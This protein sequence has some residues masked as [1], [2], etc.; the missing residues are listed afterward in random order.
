VTHAKVKSLTRR[1][2]GDAYKFYME[3]FYPLQIY[4]M[5][6]TQELSTDRI[7]KEWSETLTVK[8]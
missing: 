3:N 4:L 2:E 1:E 8:H 6:S 5:T 7:I